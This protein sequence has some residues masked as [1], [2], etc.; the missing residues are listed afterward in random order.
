ML[1]DSQFCNKL[2]CRDSGFV[3]SLESQPLSGLVLV[4]EH[5]KSSI[6]QGYKADAPS[7]SFG[8]PTPSC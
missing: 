5:R 6:V 2:Q 3:Q 4:P 1:V 7:A 8:Q